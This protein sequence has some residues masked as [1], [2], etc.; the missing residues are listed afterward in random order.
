[1]LVANKGIQDIAFLYKKGTVVR[2]VQGDPENC[3]E[4]CMAMHSEKLLVM[5]YTSIDTWYFL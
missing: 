3:Q 5:I 1:M 4:K 2:I